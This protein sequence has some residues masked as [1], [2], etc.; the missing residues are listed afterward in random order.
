MKELRCKLYQKRKI[1]PKRKSSDIPKAFSAEDSGT[2]W[3][4]LGFFYIQS[5]KLQLL[6]QDWMFETNTTG[7][8]KCKE[9]QSLGSWTSCWIKDCFHRIHFQ[10]S[11][12][13][14]SYVDI[15]TIRSHM[16]REESNSTW[17]LCVSSYGGRTEGPRDMVLKDN[18]FLLLVSTLYFPQT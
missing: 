3:F 15:H 18:G 8:E 4:C 10:Q 14:G 7:R 12:G 11:L 2:D 16:K 13:G 9:L 5:Y 1:D 17:A 6:L